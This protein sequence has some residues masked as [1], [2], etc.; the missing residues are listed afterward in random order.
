MACYVSF[1]RKLWDYEVMEI[2]PEA[3]D[4][5]IELAEKEGEL[6]VRMHD[7]LSGF[8]VKLLAIVLESLKEKNSPTTLLLNSQ[9]EERLGQIKDLIKDVD[10][11]MK[12]REDLTKYIAE[13]KKRGIK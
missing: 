6:F 5:M 11:F 7:C 13:E 1:N 3:A 9:L 12:D 10:Q 8:A 4:A 2:G